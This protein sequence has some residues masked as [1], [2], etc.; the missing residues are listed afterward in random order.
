M[1][2]STSRVADPN[3]LVR[4]APNPGPQSAA[5]SCPSEI[6]LYGGAAY[7]G[8]TDLLLISAALNT[9]F[10]GYTG[11]IFRRT[12][13][14]LE[15]H[16]IDRTRQLYSGIGRYNEKEYKWT[17]PTRD[18]KGRLNNGESHIYLSY[19]ERDADVYN[20]HGAAYQFIGF[21]EST[22]FSAFQIRYL[23]GRLRYEPN[24]DPRIRK[25]LLL[26]TNPIGPGL[27][28]HKLMFIEDAEHG[29]REPFM[30]YKD[31]KWPD[32]AEPVYKTTCFIPAK[33]WD[34]PVALKADPGYID[35][36]RSQGGAVARALLYGSWD[37]QISMAV[38]FDK[39]V[40]TIDPIPIPENAPRWIGIDW[41]K[42]DKACAV[43]QTAFGGKVYW[44]RDLA[45]PGEEIVPF[46]QEIVAA[47]I[48]EKI[49]FVVLSHEAFADRGQGFGH[50]QADQF[51]NVFS[52]A[53]IPVVRSDKDPEGRLMLLRE[54]LRTTKAPVSENSKGVDDYDFWQAKVL[55]EGERAWKE[56]ARLKE[57]A[58][59]G[60]LPRLQVFRRLPNNM[61]LGCPY[62]IQSLPL[63]T[64][65]LEKPKRIA[66]GQDDHGFDA[67]T[68]GLK[69]YIFNDETKLLNAYM[70]QIGGQLPTS[71]IAAQL[72]M[73]A[74]EQKLQEESEGGEDAPFVMENEPAR[75]GSVDLEPGPWS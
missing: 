33:I 57:V 22:M 7:G 28:W 27:G 3:K 26:T 39:Y 8:K 24:A 14:E 67:G 30:I 32:I 10:A 16:I 71:G 66:E 45:R 59:D 42:R 61:G 34:N 44:Y 2:F 64:V 13:K 72:A 54:F 6:L 25:Q 29:R 38:R 23:L 46:A 18:T 60:E 62:I 40:H 17:F 20:H 74:A 50:T 63:L 51:V 4:W 73:E 43:W 1:T 37:E 31:A 49:D 55:S 41:G 70:E 21:D 48:G 36:L 19:L 15:K 69:G 35:N 56:Y 5:L 52:R 75:D 65:D 53:N 68:Y 58:T 11:I 9:P 47:S 12:Y